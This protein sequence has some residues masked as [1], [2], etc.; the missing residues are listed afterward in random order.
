MPRAILLNSAEAD[1]TDIWEYLAQ[2]STENA[3]SFVRRLQSL[4][5]STLAS[6]PYI[7]R[8]REEIAPSLRSLP[9]HGYIVFFRPITDGVEIVR[10]LQGSR[11]IEAIFD[12]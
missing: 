12:P 2:D 10:V 11:D 5:E 9:F 8:S 3:T 7:G 6:N 1:L 4:C